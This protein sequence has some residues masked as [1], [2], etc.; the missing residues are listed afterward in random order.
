MS[1]ILFASLREFLAGLGCQ[2]NAMPG[3]HVSFK[4][5]TS[6]A[7]IVL[8]FHG[9]DEAVSPTD[10]AVVRRILDEFGVLPRER[11]DGALR[12]HALAG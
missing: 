12:D 10:L 9:D 2:V 7:L 1:P 8:R 5:P 11:F 4:H 3:S 6:G